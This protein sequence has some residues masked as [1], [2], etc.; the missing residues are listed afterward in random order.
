MEHIGDWN[1]F[2]CTH[3]HTEKRENVLGL[4]LVLLHCFALPNANAVSVRN[5]FLAYLLP[6]SVKTW[7]IAAQAL[8]P[9]VGS[10]LGT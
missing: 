7:T 6:R 3:L 5:F 2:E 8:R 4:F 9:Y 10:Y 1:L